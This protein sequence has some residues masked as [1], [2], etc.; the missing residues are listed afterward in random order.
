MLNFTIFLYI[1]LFAFIST[2]LWICV[3]KDKRKERISLQTIKEI[4]FFF[5]CYFF[6]LSIVKVLLGSAES[7]LFESFWDIQLKTYVNYGMPLLV[8]SIIMPLV[9]RFIFREKAFK[10]IKSADAFMLIALILVWILK[11][12]ISNGGYC[13]AFVVSAVGALLYAIFYKQE[14]EY[15]SK[16]EYKKY[17]VEMLPAIG[18]WIVTVGIYLPN[19]LYLANYSQ[20]SGEYWM[21]FVIM[22]LG[23]II[24]GGIILFVSLLLLPKALFKMLYLLLAG[25]ICMG[26]IQIMFLNG[27]LKALD[28]VDQIWSV[29]TKVVNVAIWVLIIA[30]IL[31]VGYKKAIVAKVCKFACLYV[32]AIQIVTLGVLLISTDYGS[33]KAQEAMST[34]GA[35][36]LSQ[37]GNVLVFVL[38]C[39]ESNWFEDIVEEDASIIEP[40]ADFTYYRNGTS[41]FAHTDNAIPYMLTGVT[42]KEEIAGNYANYAYE[43]SDALNRIAENGYDIGIYTGA[44]YLAESA[45]ALTTNYRNDSS[46][47]YSPIETLKWMLKSSMYKMMPFILKPEYV[48][49]SGDVFALAKSDEVWNIDNDLPF[50][51]SLMQQGLTVNEESS[52]AFRFYH[53]RGPHAPFYLSEDI[54]YEPT[55]R[56]ATV[57]SQGRGSLKIVYEYLNQMKELGIYDDAT[58]IITADHGQGYISDSDKTSGKPDRTSRPIFIIKRPNEQG[59][60]MRISNA[61]VSQAELIPTILDAVGT[62]GSD[63]GRTFEDISENE[64]RERMYVDVYSYF[65]VQYTINGDA[66]DL[67][68]WDIKKAVYQ[69]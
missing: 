20:F 5:F 49:Y 24:C 34:E 14:M 45:K 44:S 21:F 66:A 12:K 40:L 60:A 18:A 41:Q 56:E 68:S 47:T 54:K 19:E 62:D 22:L 58:I 50:Y 33:G 1:L 11:G 65:T 17:T 36:E 57:S 46:W 13:I 35:L 43:N 28:G 27:E 32:A 16:G 26:Y 23:S 8:F 3:S 7:T 4:V 51:N 9:L 48:Y 64:Q 29:E 53:M 69:K 15:I 6:L 59:E 38:D 10:L 2:V 42:W 52:P 25:V 67:E 30:I 37:N 63:Y 39:F 61:P 55:G 31:F